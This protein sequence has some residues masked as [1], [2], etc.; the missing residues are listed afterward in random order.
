MPS[1]GPIYRTKHTEPKW[2]KD[3]ESVYRCECGYPLGEVL[4]PDTDKPEPMPKK[5]K[6]LLVHSEPPSLLLGWGLVQCG[7]C[8]K[9][10]EWTLKPPRPLLT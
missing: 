9:W 4:R 1:I 3:A 6:C 5:A 8:G 10:G 7:K 2:V